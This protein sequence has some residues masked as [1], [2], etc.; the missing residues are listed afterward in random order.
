MSHS[1][2]MWAVAAV[3]IISLVIASF[4]AFTV[5]AHAQTDVVGTA[6]FRNAPILPAGQY[7]DQIVSGDTAWYS[8]VYTN[9]TPYRFAVRLSG[10]GSDELELAAS[11]VAPTL[12][13]V[14]GPDQEIT[15]SGVIYP[16]G[17]TNVWFLKVTLATTGTPGVVH[18]FVLDI[19]GVESTRI[20]N[21]ASLVDCSLDSD[22]AA[23]DDQFASVSDELEVA[24]ARESTDQVR[25]E[26]E[27]LQ[28]FFE[29]SEAFR[30]AAEARLAQA[31]SQM[32]TLCAPDTTCTEFPE[33][34]S[35]TPFLGWVV[36]ALALGGGAAR[37]ATKP[38]PEETLED[39]VPPPT[40][41]PA[42]RAIAL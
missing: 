20:E 39:E 9:E 33:P 40:P 1:L 7:A 38:R 14:A 26:I 12:D 35:T 36:G 42:K 41:E 29:T 5:Q 31:E 23:L 37:L 28:G 22:L 18:D 17:Q 11:F 13:T 32:A 8:F 25:Q 30:P 24:L 6:D 19:E 34:A 3:A 27:N 21:C 15:G 10:P 4:A 2:R 16:G